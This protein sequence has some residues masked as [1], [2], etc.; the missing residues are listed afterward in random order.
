MRKL[1]TVLLL[2]LA[3]VALSGCAGVSLIRGQT[4]LDP[5]NPDRNP[6]E[7]TLILYFSDDQA[8]YVLPEERV[9][10]QI[11]ETLPELLIRELIAGPTSENLRRTIPEEVQLLGISVEDGVAFVDFSEEMRSKHWG[12]SAGELMTIGSV[13]N[14]L[15][16]LP[17]IESVQFLIEGQVEESIWGH[18]TTSEP[19]TRMDGLIGE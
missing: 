3:L 2:V 10:E 5:I 16:E 4:D 13:V 8:M 12:G 19:F 7:V 17:E 14:T 18:A 1:L 11:E 15:T 9:V 6:Q